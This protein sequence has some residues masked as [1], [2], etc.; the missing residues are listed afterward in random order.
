MPV[1]FILRRMV[2]EWRLLS[3]LLVALC[4]VTGFMA[5]GPLYVRAV[6]Q[7]ELDVTL[8]NT[9]QGQFNISLVN[10]LPIDTAEAETIIREEMGTMA[11][12]IERMRTTS[13]VH[14]GLRYVPGEPIGQ[15][16]TTM[17]EGCYRILSYENVE[18][19]FTLVDG[20]W[21]EVIASPDDGQPQIEAVISTAAAERMAL[22]IGDRVVIGT[23]ASDYT[24][25]EIVGLV[26]VALSPDDPFWQPPLWVAHRIAFEPRYFQI[27]VNFDRYDYG[28]IVRDDMYDEWV[29]PLI[30]ENRYHHYI[31]ID[32]SQIRSDNIEAIERS[33]SNVE[34]RLRL[35]YPEMSVLTGMSGVITGFRNSINSV[36]GPIVLLSGA[37]LVLMLYNLVTTSGLILEQQSAE[38]SA[39]SARGGGIIQLVG[40]QFITA[41]VLGAIAALLGPI[42]ARLILLILAAV[43]P[44]SEILEDVTS[45]P[46]PDTSLS[47]SIIAAIIAVLILTIPA[48]T[49]AHNSQ[50]RLRAAMSRPPT[51]PTWTRYYIDWMMIGIGFIFM[52]RLYALNTEEGIT[53]LLGDPASFVRQVASG[54]AAESLNDPFNLAGPALLLTGLILL[55]LRLFPYLMRLPGLLLRGLNGLTVRLALWNVERDPGH[56]A[57]L[58]LLL[59]GTV[60]LGT[61]SLALAHT[62][63]LGAEAVA[64]AEVGADAVITLDPSQADS[65][66]DWSTLGGVTAG[67]SA[68]M[69]ESTERGT[70]ER[71]YI[72]GIDP[73]TFSATFPDTAAISTLLDESP[74]P[75]YPGMVLPTDIVEIALEVYALP[76]PEGQET[77]TRVGIDVMDANG[78]ITTVMLI[79]EDE[80]ASERFVSYRGAINEDRNGRQPWRLIGIRFSHVRGQD[81]DFG[82]TVILDDMTAT[83]A[84]GESIPIYDFEEGTRTDWFWPRIAYQRTEDTSLYTETDI[85]AE[86][87]ASLLIVHRVGGFGSISRIPVLEL[88]PIGET[89]VSVILSSSL[90]QRMGTR[91][92]FRRP[93]EVG[94]DVSTSVE[95]RTGN[96]TLPF[97]VAAIIDG[98]PGLP[99]DSLYLVTTA[100]SARLLLNQRTNLTAFYGINR[101]WLTFDQR[102]PQPDTFVAIEAVPG[103]R[104]ATYAVARFNIIQRDPLANALTGMLFA[105][106]WVSLGLSLLDFAFYMRVTARRRTT[107]F[108]VLQAMGWNTGSIWRLLTIE[109]A[110]LILPALV[111][112]VV[113]GTLMAYLILPFLALI[114]SAVLNLPLLDVGLLLLVL[115]VAFTLLLAMAAV[116]L[117]H[118]PLQQSLRLGQE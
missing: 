96:V 53:G 2:R 111:V 80:F 75:D 13:D 61:A 34:Q 102:N 113:L 97:R 15:G 6:A 105:G 101:A 48:W 42:I 77:R 33:L 64:R 38:W 58:V 24:L 103:Y 17:F 110:A 66:L 88:H 81:F 74:Q 1:G 100:D 84:A 19:L 69:E 86:G 55:W 115:I 12:D 59:I 18:S 92:T 45:V 85:V 30:D 28:L 116:A 78:V 49:A 44:Q 98:F 9:R 95:L 90:A 79:G 22:A 37:V 25:V 70:G 65:M 40:M 47:L 89:P 109:H 63:N 5:L 43:G 10:A 108:A 76:D 62:R 27:D 93:L 14:C 56:C 32:S 94:D 106:F 67:T 36:E 57:Q 104:E 83:T 35:N 20:R 60:A 29:A 87:A 71:T 112:G 54:E 99:D 7:A 31:R 50:E 117:R 82:H 26:D 114:G 46:F 91:S 107:T 23:E 68:I 72:I 4:L 118:V 51:R 21:P 11:L 39:I 8:A 52:L 41:S 73:A 3:V 16:G